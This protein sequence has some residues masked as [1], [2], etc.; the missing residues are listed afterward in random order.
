M[1]DVD[2]LIVGA[3]ATGLGFADRIL[4]NSSATMAIIDRRPLPAGHWVDAYPF[5]RLHA[6]SV[7]YGVDSMPLGHDE[8]DKDGLNAGLGHCARGAEII[9]HYE[10]CLYERLIPSGR[11]RYLPAHEMSAD[12]TIRRCIDG[13]EVAINARKIV[14]ASYFTN[15]VPK[16]DPPPFPVASDANL[17]CPHDLPSTA[18]RYSKFVVIGSGKTGM[19]AVTF[20][21]GLGARAEQIQWIVPRDPWVFNREGLQAHPSFLK[22]MVE[23]TAAQLDAMALSSSIEDFEARMEHGEVWLRLDPSV[24]PTMFHAACASKRECL[25]LNSVSI[26]REGYVQAIE[27]NHLLLTGGKLATDSNTLLIN[28]AASALTKQPPI[29]IFDENRITMQFLRFPAPA[30]S[31]AMIAE[32]ETAVVG[33]DK[34][35]YAQPTGVTDVSSDFLRTTWQQQQNQLAW[36]GHPELKAFYRN[37]RLDAMGRL[38]RSGNRHDPLLKPYFDRIQQAGPRAIEN[39]PVLLQQ[40][41]T[42]N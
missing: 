30:F 25:L 3:G 18:T 19:D 9:A 36:N 29:P 31:A 28:C 17:V 21:L 23:L 32:I 33:P 20:L 4:T 41:S 26:V 24:R 37:T 27:K 8:L 22:R 1:I 40:E 38:V 6:P 15:S 14:D 11:V 5:V 39:I 12:G 10:N 7:L 42:P 16:T 34:N 13:S 35:R 2:Y